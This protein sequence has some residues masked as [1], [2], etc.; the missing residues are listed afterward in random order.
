MMLAKR[1]GSWRKVA[2]LIKEPQGAV[3]FVTV[4]EFYYHYSP[5]R[6]QQGKIIYG[7]LFVLPLEILLLEMP[8]A[9]L[10]GRLKA[11]YSL[12]LADAFIAATALHHNL[13]LVHRDGDFRQVKEVEQ[14]YLG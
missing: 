5:H 9:E 7:Q 10:A 12:G 11:D 13:T 6:S 4:S 3:S 14:V 1:Q 2:D 8:L